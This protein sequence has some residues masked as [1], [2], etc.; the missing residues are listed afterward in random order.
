MAVLSLLR[1][2]LSEKARA[3]V[4][5]TEYLLVK[6]ASRCNL[7]CTYCYWFRDESVYTQAA[8]LQD[9]VVDALL[10]KLDRHIRSYDLKSFFILFHGGEPALYGVERFEK[11]V[12]RLRQLEKNC[13][14]SLRLAMTTNGL[15]LNPDWARVLRTYNV[16]VTI[17]I[18]GPA[19]IHDQRRI[20]ARG[21]GTAARVLDAIAMLRAND[22]EPGIL[23]VCTPTMDPADLFEHFITELKFDQFDVLIPDATH[24]DT[25]E[26]IADFYIRLFDLWFDKWGDQGVRIRIIDNLVRGLIGAQ[27]NAEGL[28]Y[29]PNLHFSMLPD[30]SLEALDT[31]R[32]IGTDSTHSEMNIKTHEIQELQ[33]DPFWREALEASLHLNDKCRRCPYHLACGGAHLGWRWSNERRFD[34]PSVYCDD[35]QAIFGHVWHRIADDLLVARPA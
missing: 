35:L 31:L 17:S 11:L 9:A 24:E 1:P 18:D 14:I 30:G 16:Q 3:A 28:G 33:N 20:D 19:A 21:R 2:G 5:P 34:N 13:G 29:G 10:E 15:L 4:R 32:M 7:R 26:P 23:A 27:S 22:V 8:L 25:I 12:A 6:L